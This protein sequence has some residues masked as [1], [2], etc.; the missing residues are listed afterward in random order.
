LR[1]SDARSCTAAK[2]RFRR[3]G[4]CLWRWRVRPLFFGDNID[5]GDD[6][7]RLFFVRLLV[8]WRRRFRR[9]VLRFGILWLAIRIFE[10]ECRCG[11]GSLP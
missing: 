8:L 7:D 10:W 3:I 9:R 11:G 6:V 1:K 4:L 5:F 2:L